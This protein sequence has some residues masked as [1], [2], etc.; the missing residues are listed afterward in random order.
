[1]SPS[2]SDADAILQ[3]MDQWAAALQRRDAAAMS[4]M[5]TEDATL[6]DVKP[7]WVMHGAQA[8]RASWEACF[9]YLPAR[10]EAQRR[11]VSLQV[12][13]DVAVCHCLSRIAPLDDPQHPAGASW[14]RITIALR[15]EQGNWRVFHEHGS[16]PFD[17]VTDR[18]VPIPVEGE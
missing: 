5:Y 15:K 6:F 12:G 1:M 8:Y 16:L 11:A 18:V 14:L 9:P 4:A 10:F 3:L 13:G 2:P 17:P 7:P